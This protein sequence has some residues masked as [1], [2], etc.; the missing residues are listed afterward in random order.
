MKITWNPKTDE[1]AIVGVSKAERFGL[2]HVLHEA[3]DAVLRRIADLE[4][5]KDTV[6]EMIEEDRAIV[7]DIE[8][9]IDDFMIC[10]VK[11]D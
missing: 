8:R 4:I 2:I 5:I 7:S 1:F 9:M 6:P 11:E 10:E 3:K